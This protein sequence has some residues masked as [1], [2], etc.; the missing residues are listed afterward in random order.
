MQANQK[1]GR[2]EWQKV[3]RELCRINRGN[4]RE[5]ANATKNEQR[6]INTGKGPHITLTYFSLA[7]ENEP[8]KGRLYFWGNFS[9]S[10]IFLIFQRRANLIR[11]KVILINISLRLSAFHCE[12][13]SEQSLNWFCGLTYWI[14]GE[15]HLKQFTDVVYLIAYLQTNIAH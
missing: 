14:D 9:P 1:E 6:G 12:I 7:K 15:R 2:A 10:P 3:S 11:G 13:K 8:N 4:T 5:C